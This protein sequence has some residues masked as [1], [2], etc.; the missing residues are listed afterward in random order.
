[1]RKRDTRF[2]QVLASREIDPAA[3]EGLMLLDHAWSFATLVDAEQ[4]LAVVEGLL[5]R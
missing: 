5:Y 1:L 4:S 3:S 2:L